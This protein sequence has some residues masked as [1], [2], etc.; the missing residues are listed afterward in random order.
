[1]WIHSHSHTKRCLIAVLQSEAL[2]KS[3]FRVYLIGYFLVAS[4]R[5][6]Q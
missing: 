3:I 6:V 4:S 5:K 1:M 2:Q